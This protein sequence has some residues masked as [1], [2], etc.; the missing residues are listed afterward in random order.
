MVSQTSSPVTPKSNQ[1]ALL[2]ELT[3]RITGTDQDG[4]IVRI[5]GAKCTIGASSD[6]TLRLIF[7]GISPIHCLIHRGPNGMGIRRYSADTLLNGQEFTDSRLI[8]G[9]RLSV[10]PIDL[11]V[12]ANGSTDTSQVVGQPLPT[13]QAALTTADHP[14]STDVGGAPRSTGFMEEQMRAFI[15]RE[16]DLMRQEFE[17]SRSR[18]EFDRKVAAWEADCKQRLADLDQRSL[19]L[20]TDTARL[21]Q[22]RD[23]FTQKQTAGDVER[24]QDLDRLA[25]EC[26]LLRGQLIELQA[27]RD[28]VREESKLRLQQ[29]S[30]QIAQWT[31][32]RDRLAAELAETRAQL[33]TVRS[34][35][36]QQLVAKESELEQ[37]SRELDRENERLE[38]ARAALEDR[39]SSLTVNSWT[40]EQDKL[41]AE[42]TELAALRHGLEE[43]RAAWEEQHKQQLAELHDRCQQLETERDAAHSRV[44]LLESELS[45]LEGQ[46]VSQEQTDSSVW[47]EERTKLTGQLQARQR[48]LDELTTQWQRDRDTMQRELD[49]RSQEL[50]AEIERLT[51]DRS[52]FQREREAWDTQRDEEAQELDGASQRAAELERERTDLQRQIAEFDELRATFYTERER[53]LKEL[54]SIK[55]QVATERQAW[56]AE[57]QQ[58]EKELEERV[59]A[60]EAQLT[61]ALNDEQESG[62]CDVPAGLRHQIADALDGE[63]VGDDETSTM[64]IE[65]LE[66]LRDQAASSC[67]VGAGDEGLACGAGARS[68]EEL[69]FSAPPREAPVDTASI[70]A[71]F[72]Y[73]ADEEAEDDLAAEP[74]SP[75]ASSFEENAGDENEDGDIQDYMAR[76]LQRMGTGAA[77]QG[78]SPESEPAARRKT[79]LRPK[80]VPAPTRNNSE[81]VLAPGEFVPRARAPEVVSNLQS[82]RDL[83]N[84]SARSDIDKHRRR[85]HEALALLLWFVAIVAVAVGGTAFYWAMSLGI[86]TMAGYSAMGSLAL[87]ACCAFQALAMTARAR[88][89]GL[90]KKPV[91][92]TVAAPLPVDE[93]AVDDEPAP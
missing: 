89:G 86:F 61:Q 69:Q 81:K 71:K 67:D 23:A 88:M 13:P 28:R 54:Q 35:L 58:A 32:E 72:G 73:S 79:E 30:E 10:G 38:A 24:R 65:M 26:D 19:Q 31:Q 68:V 14:T 40:N 52:R 25:G 90:S 20:H 75:P 48:E 12:L 8:V 29:S 33:M 36:D 50:Q 27:D 41:Q 34:E 17:L 70:L 46:V 64:A 4:R 85:R 82:L 18:E 84:T 77:R 16:R 93:R 42:W 80:T 87:S 47:D 37:R 51:Q 5:R 83:A 60:L 63:G 22:D 56:Q 45:H 9:D 76:L 91:T 49:E 21:E 74:V 44:G 57:R 55:E 53:D 62:S 6:C 78:Q 59:Q 43:E 3:L 15:D 7:P 39:Q 92:R 1:S 66:L 2:G 11:I